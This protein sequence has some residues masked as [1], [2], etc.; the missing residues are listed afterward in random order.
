MKPTGKLVVA[1]T[2]MVAVLLI[3]EV[4]NPQGP[5][6]RI[7]EVVVLDNDSMRLVLLTYQP[8]ADSDL[9]LNLGPE[10]TIV[11]EGEL[12]LYTSKGQEVLKAGTVHW[13]PASTVHLDRNETDRPARFWSLLLKRCD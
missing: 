13:L 12:T 6:G 8:G 4:G 2:L 10:M 9:H 11:Q 3:G 1:I 5:R 7:D